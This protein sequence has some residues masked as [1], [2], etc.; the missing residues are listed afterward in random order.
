WAISNYAA[1]YLV[2]GNPLAAGGPSSPREEGAARI[3][4]TFA[5]GTS[6]TVVFAERYGTCGLSNGAVNART[7]F[8]SLWSNSNSFWRPAFCINN[9][10]QVPSRGGYV[11]CALFQV[12]PQYLMDCDSSLAQSPHPSGMNVGLG[13]CSVRFVR[14][15]ITPLTWQHACD[16]QDG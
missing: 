2:F 1:N 14:S 6:N 8:G 5:D 4:T 16:P 7:T 12:Q 13:D 9:A 10:S 15:S 3:P 11:P